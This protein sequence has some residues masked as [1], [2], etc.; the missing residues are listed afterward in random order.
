MAVD[1]RIRVLSCVAV[2]FRRSGAPL[3]LARCYESYPQDEFQID[4]WTAGKLDS[5]FSRSWFD[6]RG[7]RLIEARCLVSNPV[8]KRR[9]AEASLRA[10]MESESYDLIHVNSAAAWLQKAALGIAQ[11]CGVPVRIAHSHGNG[12][13]S[14][15]ARLVQSFEASG[16][17]KIA[18]HCAACSDEAGRFLFGEDEWSRRGIVIPNGIDVEAFR[19]DDGVRRAVRERYGLDDATKVIACVGVVGKVKNQRFLIEHMPQILER[20]PGALLW[21]I[22]DDSRARQEKSLANKLG[23]DG[24]VKFLGQVD[25]VSE[26]MQAS[27]VLAVP[28]LNEGF[29][30]A[31]LEGEA[32]GLPCVITADI[33]EIAV[34]DELAV[35]RV[36][37]TDGDAWVGALCEAMHCGRIVEAW[38]TVLEKGLSVEAMAERVFTLYR[39]A[40]SCMDK[41]EL[42]IASSSTDGE[43]RGLSEIQEALLELLASFVQICDDNE[44]AYFAWGGSAL[45][46]VRHKGF[47]PWDDD[48][49]IAMPR[50]DFDRLRAISASG[51]LPDGFAAFDS[52]ELLYGVFE[53]R[54]RRIT[55][56]NEAWDERQPFLSLD[57]FPLDGV[58]DNPVVRKLHVLRCR[59][60]FVAIKLKRIRYIQSVEGMKNRG[61]TRPKSEQL[62]I[63]FGGLF[64]ALLS[65]VSEQELVRRYGKATKKYAYGATKLVAYYSS[66]YRSKSMFPIWVAGRGKLVPFESMSVRVFS[67]VEDYLSRVFGNAYMQ[68]PPED[69]R[70][71]HGDLRLV[72]QSEAAKS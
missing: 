28:S 60:L 8:L 57:L 2:D 21:L 31:L 44:L 58:P 19:H 18:T 54:N 29:S 25:N 53:D 33:P 5:S 38:Q 59:A 35:M 66:R 52:D 49:D 34:V 40:Q 56:G 67:E 50:P 55:H 68:L 62:L 27:D 22:G 46:A 32:A 48:V 23:I 42:G 45:G 36:P 43:D 39:G 47:I 12:S 20:E 26:L 64:N 72:D 9:K 4:I 1:G 10:V 61:E 37:L 65:F 24:R 3:F 30:F 15:A 51:K 14:G 13:R 70:E 17:G 41:E 11:E 7:I 63:R 16:L 6:E 71:R 69:A